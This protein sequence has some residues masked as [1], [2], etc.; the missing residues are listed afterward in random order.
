MSIK[1]VTF[2]KIPHKDKILSLFVQNNKYYI[3]FE[4]ITV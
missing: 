4:I 2:N 1:L 3:Y